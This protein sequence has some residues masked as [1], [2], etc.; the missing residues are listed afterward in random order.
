MKM[1]TPYGTF[2]LRILV[3]KNDRLSVRL[4]SGRA[5]SGCSVD[6]GAHH[7]ARKHFMSW[8]KNLFAPTQPRTIY[9]VAMPKVRVPS[10]L[11]WPCDG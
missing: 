5:P 4:G 6:L 7:L 3:P 10:I 11:A 2:S 9:I 1:G 8:W